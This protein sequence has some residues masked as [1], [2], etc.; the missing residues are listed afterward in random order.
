M[1]GKDIRGTW[2][3]EEKDRHYA[4]LPSLIGAMP[5]QQSLD[6]VWITRDRSPI[7]CLQARHELRFCST[8]GAQTRQS[9]SWDYEIDGMARAPI[10]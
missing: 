7:A 3:G 4:P 9:W 10:V 5:C 2:L 1:V 8:I 6:L